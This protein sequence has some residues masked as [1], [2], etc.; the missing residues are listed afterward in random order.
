MKLSRKSKS[1]IF[2]HIKNEK[3]LLMLTEAVC[4]AIEDNVSEIGLLT[5]LIKN[6]GQNFFTKMLI[7]KGN[8]NILVN[9]IKPMTL[10]LTELDLRIVLSQLEAFADPSKTFKAD[11]PEIT[12]KNNKVILCLNYKDV[13]AEGLK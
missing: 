2:L 9:D 11:Y 3:E 8:E 12:I 1:I 4:N 7:S 13:I 6:R 10:I 5:N